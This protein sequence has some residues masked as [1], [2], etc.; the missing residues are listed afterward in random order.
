MAEKHIIGI[1][2][3]RIATGGGNDGMFVAPDPPMPY[4]NRTDVY[5]NSTT[6]LMNQKI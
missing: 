5:W 3:L 6:E 1:K 4:F 2:G